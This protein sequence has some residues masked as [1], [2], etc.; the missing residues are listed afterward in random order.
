MSAFN[1]AVATP[2]MLQALA[3]EMDHAGELCRRLE[4]LV[5]TLVAASQGAAREEGMREAQVLDALT[6][7]IDALGL[8]MREVA[9]GVDT[10][11]ACDL[12]DVLARLPLAA[13]AARLS[14][15]VRN[16]SDP[17][18]PPADAGDL[19]LF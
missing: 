11:G 10:T 13:L 15:R 14:E 9:Q 7:H 3:S 5:S 6:Q 8:F 12:G 16:T 19:V 4:H 1:P 2:S 17:S 18:R